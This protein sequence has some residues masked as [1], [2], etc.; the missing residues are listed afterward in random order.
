MRTYLGSSEESPWVCV[1]WLP[2]ASKLGRVELRGASQEWADH[3]GVGGPKSRWSAEGA[4]DGDT[5]CAVKSSNKCPRWR[6][7]SSLNF[8]I[9]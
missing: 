6:H 8:M 9:T 4:G 5:G 1:F 7:E 2:C 3:P